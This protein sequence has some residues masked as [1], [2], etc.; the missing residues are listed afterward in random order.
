VF[1]DINFNTTSLLYS[2]EQSNSKKKRSRLSTIKETDEFKAKVIDGVKT[3][4]SEQMDKN[5]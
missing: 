3:N 4:L 5:T 2:Q 1:K